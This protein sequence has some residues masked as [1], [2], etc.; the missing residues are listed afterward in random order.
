M[1]DLRARLRQAIETAP[2]PTQGRGRLLFPS[3]FEQP[4]LF[5]AQQNRIERPRR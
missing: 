4:R 3:A 2:R 1:C 5:E